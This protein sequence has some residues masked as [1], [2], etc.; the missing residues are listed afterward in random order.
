MRATYIGFSEKPQGLHEVMLK[1]GFEYIGPSQL[2]NP[3]ITSYNYKIYDPQEPKNTGIG[4]VLH[5]GVVKPPNKTLLRL[6]EDLGIVADCVF[7][8][9]SEEEDPS[10][11]QLLED[12][13]SFFMMHYKAH[14]LDFHDEHQSTE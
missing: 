11:D 7:V 9:R 6:Y 2:S 5:D 3:M 4:F 14:T 13:V 1:F 12:V 10:F 8:P